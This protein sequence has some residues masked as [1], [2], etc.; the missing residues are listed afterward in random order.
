M[1]NIK[2]QFYDKV[3]D[4]FVKFVVIVSRYQNQWV[5]VKHK[6]RETY[7]IPGGHRENG[8]PI[9]E[10]AKRELEE[11]TGAKCYSIQPVVYYSVIGKTRVNQTGEESFGMIFLAD[12]KSFTDIHSEIERMALFDDLPEYLTYPHIQPN[13]IDYIKDRKS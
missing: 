11:E 9:L 2:V 5:F 4:E 7:E 10:A 13:M 12:I 6:E 3:Q 8:E 1:E